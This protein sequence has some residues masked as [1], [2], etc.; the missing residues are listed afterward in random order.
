LPRPSYPPIGGAQSG[1][2]LDCSGALSRPGFAYLTDVKQLGG[3]H[4]A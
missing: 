2:P 1:N 3:P 4:E